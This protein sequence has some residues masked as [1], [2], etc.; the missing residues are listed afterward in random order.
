[1]HA[2]NCFW[3]GVGGCQVAHR[4]LGHSHARRSNLFPPEQRWLPLMQKDSGFAVYWC[5]QEDKPVRKKAAVFYLL[6]VWSCFPGLEQIHKSACALFG[7]RG[8]WHGSASGTEQLCI[9]PILSAAFLTISSG[10]CSA[11][12]RC[13]WRGRKPRTIIMY[14]HRALSRA[15]LPIQNALFVSRIAIVEYIPEYSTT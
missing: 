14:V 8:G 10:H 6:P 7:A 11:M 12:K 5:N 15:A 2:T 3:W 9:G 13:R 1:M 4:L